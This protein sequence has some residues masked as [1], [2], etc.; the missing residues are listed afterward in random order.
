MILHTTLLI[1]HIQSNIIEQIFAF[2]ETDG[3]PASSLLMA[4]LH[5]QLVMTLLRDVIAHGSIDIGVSAFQV[6]SVTDRSVNDSGS[7]PTRDCDCRF[8]VQ[9]KVTELPAFYGAIIGPTEFIISIVNLVII[10]H[11]FLHTPRRGSHVKSDKTHT[12]S[13]QDTPPS[14]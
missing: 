13:H 12:H 3:R 2:I 7:L 1:A 9:C 4:S 6:V 5:D 8:S 10:Y 14:P 11:D